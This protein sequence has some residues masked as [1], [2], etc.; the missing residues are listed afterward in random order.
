MT[1]ARY[2]LDTQA[3]IWAAR[4]SRELGK[5]SARIIREQADVYFSAVSIAEMQL[6]A[7]IG[8][9]E[10]ADDFIALCTGNGLQ[11]LEFSAESAMALSRFPALARHDPFDRMI[12]AQAATHDMHLITADRVLLE[13]AQLWIIDA[14][15]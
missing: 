1:R 11:E 13:L 4:A 5:T 9:L 10:I 14:R 6:K 8:K 3:L 7:L 2:L 15:T 12:L